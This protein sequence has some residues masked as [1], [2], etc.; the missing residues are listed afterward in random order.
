MLLTLRSATSV[1]QPWLRYLLHTHTHTLTYTTAHTCVHTDTHTRPARR[2]TNADLSWKDCDLMSSSKLKKLWLCDSMDN[3]FNSRIWMCSG[4]CPKKSHFFPAKGS[5]LYAVFMSGKK[6]VCAS[7]VIR[8]PTDARKMLGHLLEQS[9]SLFSSSCLWKQ[10][11]KWILPG[12]Q[13]IP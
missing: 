9:Q 6:G 3:S 10:S 7:F 5:P 1:S 11:C 8:W 2:R 4:M 12:R 13:R